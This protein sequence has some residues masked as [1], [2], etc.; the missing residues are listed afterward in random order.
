MGDEEWPVYYLRTPR[1]N[2]N[3]VPPYMAMV[4]VW[5]GETACDT[6]Y[7]RLDSDNPLDDPLPDLLIGR[8]PV[9]SEAELTTVVAKIVGYETLTGGIDWRT[10]ATFI[11]DNYIHPDTGVRDPAGDFAAF[12]D[13]SAALQPAGVEIDRVYYD[14]SPTAGLTSWREPDASEVRARTI[15]ALNRGTGT[16][17]YAGHSY[18]INWGTTSYSVNYPH[19]LWISDTDDLSNG[20]RLPVVLTMTCLTSAFQVYEG[21]TIDER[22][23][24]HPNGGA[25]AVWGS[26]GL[27]VA[28]GHNALQRGFYNDMWNGASGTAATR[29]TVGQ[30]VQAGYLDLYTNGNCCQS[31]LYT[32]VLLGDPLTQMRATATRAYLPTV[33]R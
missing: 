12:A 19:L 2:T 17:M 16:V 14:P 9:K 1:I 22:I 4:D 11:A 10:R 27:G 6:C 5:L 13:N 15:A 26:S 18:Y 21:S 3:F 28:Y 30:R 29:G 7:A 24:L 25:V 32:F 8:L 23:L 33:Y 31:S 20:E